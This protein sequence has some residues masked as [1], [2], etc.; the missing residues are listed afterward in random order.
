MSVGVLRPILGPAALCLL[1]ASCASSGQDGTGASD[2]APDT[3]R[4]LNV[5]QTTIEMY[6]QAGIESRNLPAAVR[7]VWPVLEGVYAELEIPVTLIDPATWEF[8]NPAFQPRRVAGERLNSF[9]DCGSNFSGP[10]ANLYEV[11]MSV[12]TKLVPVSDSTQVVTVVDAF[13]RPRT[14]SGNQVHCQSREVLERRIIRL[15]AG[16][17]GFGPGD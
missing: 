15:V 16:R 12:V 5:G 11:D 4:R 14:T 3:R 17:L 1:L 8:G 7:D 13:A 10:L 6:N 9:I 2:V